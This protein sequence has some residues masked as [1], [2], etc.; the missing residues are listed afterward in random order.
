MTDKEVQH[1]HWC[2]YVIMLVMQ[3]ICMLS[4][5]VLTHEPS[6]AALSQLSRSSPTALF[7][8]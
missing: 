2:V 3:N 6:S 1:A 8:G 5:Q 4:M 7:F